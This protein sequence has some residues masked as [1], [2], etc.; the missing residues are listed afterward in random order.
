MQFTLRQVWAWL[1]KACVDADPRHG[2][3]KN[4]LTLRETWDFYVTHLEA[5]KEAR[6]AAAKRNEEMRHPMAQLESVA[7]ANVSDELM[8]EASA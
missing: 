5:E 4:F 8:D 7:V 6:Q 3:P 1:N 2:R